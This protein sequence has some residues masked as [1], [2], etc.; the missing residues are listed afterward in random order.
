MGDVEDQAT[1]LFREGKEFATRGCDLRVL[2]R[3]LNSFG[4]LQTIA[5]AVGE[6]LNPQLE[7][8]R[9]ADETVDTGLRVAVRYG[10]S[11]TYLWAGQ[12]RQC[13]GTAEQGLLLAQGD[14]SLGADIIGLSPS[15]GLKSTHGAALSLTGSPRDGAAELDRVIELARTSEQGGGPRAG[16]LLLWFSHALHVFR[17]EVTGEAAS[18]LAHGRE[19]VDYAER[20]GNQIGR[21]FGYFSLGRANVLNGAWHDALEG[22][23]KALAISRERRLLSPE[24]GMLAGMAA[25]YLGLGD[26]SKALALAEEA[27]AV[28]RRRGSRLWEFSALLTRIRVLRETQGVQARGE[29]EATLA[30]A[31]AWLEMSGAKSYEPFLHVERAELARLIGDEAARERELREAHRLFAEIGAPIRAAEVAKELEG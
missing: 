11:N 9:H 16:L 31:D 28:S 3:V 17:C 14:L 18:A 19:A 26:R 21:V 20:T 7:A 1:S 23:E 29:I 13:L 25:A 30:E 24:G 15:L 2:S 27:V 5:G 22:L 4:H 12:L 10:P 8:M 6:A